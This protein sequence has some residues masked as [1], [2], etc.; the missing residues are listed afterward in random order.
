[1]SKDNQ[2]PLNASDFNHI[3]NSLHLSKNP[4][5]MGLLLF[6]RNIIYYFSSLSKIQKA[7]I[8]NR[9]LHYFKEKNFSHKTLLEAIAILESALTE[10]YQKE[11]KLLKNKLEEEI[12][13][14]TKLIEEIA[15]IANLLL[16]GATKHKKELQTFAGDAIQ[17]LKQN[18]EPQQLI[19]FI[20]ERV[21]QL[22]DQHTSHTQKLTQ[23]IKVLE[24]KACYDYLLKNI[25]NR[26]MFDTYIQHKAPKIVA[27]GRK[28][29]LLMIDI[30][31]FKQINDRWGHLVGDEILKAL[32]RIIRSHTNVSGGKPYRYGGEELCV[33]YEDLGEDK[34][35]LR[36]EAIRLDVQTHS[37]RPPEH[38]DPPIKFTVSMGVAEM[39]SKDMPTQL[40]GKAD[41][42]LYAA[43]LSGKNQVKKYSEIACD[44]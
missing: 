31:D 15:K 23:Q 36:A 34:A 42:A 2:K 22:I 37:F 32:A 44:L 27:Q 38:S 14:K 41:K 40:V 5:W 6:V 30:D 18:Q 7:H 24:Q 19:L 26:S 35:S 3:I 16:T 4:D 10:T 33:V 17:H 12:N 13:Y 11:Q 28:L 9:I 1:M 8:Q 21:Q 43:K 29:S 25:F 20:K 39:N